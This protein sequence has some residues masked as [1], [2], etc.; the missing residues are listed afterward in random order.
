MRHE[1]NGLLQGF[2]I[3]VLFAAEFFNEIIGT[4]RTSLLPMRDERRVLFNQL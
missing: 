4:I 2:R 1:Q 3:S